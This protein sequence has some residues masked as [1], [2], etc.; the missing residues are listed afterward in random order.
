[1]DYK[2]QEAA[3]NDL[4]IQ[5]D[6]LRALYEQYFMGIEKTEPQ[7]PRKNVD[8]MFVIL[9]KERHTVRRGHMKTR[10]GWSPFEGYTL[11]GTV[12][13]TVV[14]GKIYPRVED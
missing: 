3:I 6:R 10:A 14:R 12:T 5:I 1:M 8:R 11:P 13:H 9:R 7:V 2:E 4:E